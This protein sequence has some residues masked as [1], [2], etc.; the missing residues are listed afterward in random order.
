MVARFNGTEISI[1]GATNLEQLGNGN[2]VELRGD[3]KLYPQLAIPVPTVENGL[4]KVTP[5]GRMEM[6][7]QI[8][9][10]ARWHDGTP[11][12]SDD[13]LFAWTVDQDKEMPVLRPAWYG[14]IDEVS[15]PDT[16]T[17]TLRWSRPFID[18]DRALSARFRQ[19]NEPI[20]L[21]RMHSSSTPLPEN[22]FVGT[23]YSRYRNPEWD[24]LLDRF[25]STIPFQERMQ[26]LRPVMRH[27]SD[28]LNSMGMFYDADLLV[29]NNR[30]VNIGSNTRGGWADPGV[31]YPELV[32]FRGS[33]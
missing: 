3:G 18:A 31:G 23:N 1:P 26:A 27:L 5:D 21:T 20:E 22:R 19:P 32:D 25:L 7:W 17:L 30:L 6:S 24:A 16:A 12:T 11:V 10:D 15:A 29:K 8:R 13:F 2:M 33:R 14:W 4:W 9:P 28:E